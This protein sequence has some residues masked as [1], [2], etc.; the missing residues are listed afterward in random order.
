MSG[1]WFD[2]FPDR[3]RRWMSAPLVIPTRCYPFRELSDGRQTFI[4]CKHADENPDRSGKVYRGE[5]TR[6]HD[7]VDWMFCS[8]PGDPWQYKNRYFCSARCVAVA[9]AEV[10][11]VELAPKRDNGARIWLDLGDGDRVWYLHLD[12][13]DVLVKRGD[14]VSMGQEL[15][16]M[17]GRRYTWPTHLHLELSEVKRYRPRN[18]APWFASAVHL[19]ALPPRM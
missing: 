11:I 3:V 1:R 4:S 12:R 9:D 15:A 18:P 19:P 16:G 14:I 8:A 5:Q 10:M 17:A 7:G 2:V 13:H 6:R